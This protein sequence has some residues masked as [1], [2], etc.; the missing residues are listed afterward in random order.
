[1]NKRVETELFKRKYQNKCP[2]LCRK[3]MIAFIL[4]CLHLLFP[5][6]GNTHYKSQEELE[7][8]IK[9]LKTDLNY[10]YKCLSKEINT[11]QEIPTESIEE[12]FELILD[13]E[14]S[15][16]EDAKFMAEEDPASKS[17]NEVII[18]YPGFFAVCIY[19]IAHFFYQKKI[20]LFPRILSEYAHERTGIDIHPG[21]QIASPFFIDHGTGIVIGETTTIGKNCKIYQGVTLG[22]L[23]V[24]KSLTG[25]KRHPTIEEHCLIYANATILGGDTIIGRNSVIGGNVWITKSIPQNSQVY[26]KQG[27]EIKTKNE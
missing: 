23:S 6:M 2:H 13:I 15:L 9:S 12:F 24:E 5:Q 19:R 22:A 3:Q 8:K 26:R 10:I 16:S 14:Y 21:A 20:P 4:D 27:F 17:V 1:M 7:D 18:C 11:A 25:V